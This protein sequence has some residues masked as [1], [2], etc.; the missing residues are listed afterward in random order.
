MTDQDSVATGISFAG[1]FAYLMKFQP[2]IT[3]LVLLTGLLLNVIR[4]IDRFRKKKSP[5]E[6]R[7]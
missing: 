6:D 1:V 2:E 7:D 5:S 4:I 3:V